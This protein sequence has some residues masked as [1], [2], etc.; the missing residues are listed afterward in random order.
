VDSGR[1]RPMLDPEIFPFSRAADAHRKLET[2]T[3]VGKIALVNDL[4]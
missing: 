4:I 1:I 2:G 3:T